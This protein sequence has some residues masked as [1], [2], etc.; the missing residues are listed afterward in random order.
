M[1]TTTTST[2]TLETMV[3]MGQIIAGGPPHKMK[4]V[5]GSCIALALFHPRLNRGVMAHV[6]LPDSAGRDGTPG[7]FADTAVPQML[8]LLK[9]FSANLPA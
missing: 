9:E 5:V 4:A 8:A 7:R 6:V 2:T 3:G 1:I